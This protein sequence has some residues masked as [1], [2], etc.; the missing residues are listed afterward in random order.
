MKIK[1]ETT[2][3]RNGGISTEKEVFFSVILEGWVH[4]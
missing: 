1:G 4:G 2:E 3:K